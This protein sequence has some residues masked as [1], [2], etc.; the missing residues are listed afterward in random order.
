MR[1][2]S[3]QRDWRANLSTSRSL[4]ALEFALGT[5]I[6]IGHNVFRV[7]PNEVPILAVLG[8]AS[9]RLRSGGLV[10]MGF[11]RPESW[12]RIVQIALAAAALRIALGNFVIDPVTALFWPPAIAPAGAESIAG[13][14]RSALLY[15]GLVWSFAAF[16]EEIGY[17]G[18][19]LNR[20]ADAGGRTPVAY[21]IAVVLVSILFGYGHYYKG[22]AGTS[23]PAS[24]VSFS[25]RPILSPGA[26]SG[27]RSS[28]T[29]SSIRSQWSASISAGIPR[30]PPN[31]VALR[32]S[33]HP[34]AKRCREFA[35]REPLDPDVTGGRRIPAPQIGTHD[36]ALHRQ[37]D[38]A[39]H[40]NHRAHAAPLRGA[41]TA[42]PRAAQ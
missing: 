41:R 4:S 21:W 15:I 34:D 11:R 23:I 38:R 28:R 7:L 5:C 31:R 3:G 39:A 29:A 36:A 10:A 22:P 26:I 42:G 14:M 33:Y 24:R 35:R 40:R 37:P 2:G 13:D 18:Y 8:L 9:M 16:G 19:L 1:P 30:W 20:A 6:V 12:M 17:R 27:R 25:E 32:E